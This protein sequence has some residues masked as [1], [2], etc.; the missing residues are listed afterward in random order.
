VIIVMTGI[1]TAAP[2]GRK[3]AGS[4]GIKGRKASG[5]DRS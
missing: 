5:Y 4:S 1:K 3:E 2:P